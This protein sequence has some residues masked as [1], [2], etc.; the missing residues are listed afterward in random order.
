MKHHQPYKDF[1]NNKG[2]NAYVILKSISCIK[3]VSYKYIFKHNISFTL[4]HTN[5]C[6]RIYKEQGG[7]KEIFSKDICYSLAPQL[8]SYEALE[9]RSSERKEVAEQEQ[10]TWVRN[11]LLMQELGL[12]ISLFKTLVR[13]ETVHIS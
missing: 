2:D 12:L 8:W 6:L 9:E 13:E 3:K 11:P 4:P 7:Q 5:P 1:G 10:V